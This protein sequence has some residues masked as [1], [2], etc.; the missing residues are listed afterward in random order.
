MPEMNEE[1][2]KL[3]KL[4]SEHG[5]ML[6][7]PAML[8]PANPFFDLAGEEF[9][10]RLLL[11]NGVNDVEYCLR[12]EFTIPIAAEFLQSNKSSAA[13]GYIGKIFRQRANGPA[14]FLQAGIEFLG[15]EDRNK[16][17]EKTFDF[18]L[19]AI[20]IYDNIPTL[21]LG[22]V[23]IFETLLS[24][25][26]IPKV[27]LPR[28]R[29]RFGHIKAMER[30]LARLSDPHEANTG[31][32][33]WN[34]QE[35]VKVIS[36]QM[37]AAGLSLTGSRSPEE[38]ANRYF[39]KQQLKTSKVPSETIH[40]LQNYLNVKG[41]AQGALAFIKTLALDNGINMAQSIE[42]LLNQI[43]L[44]KQKYEMSEI[45][46]DASFS[47]Q[48]DYY[49]GVVFE[50]KDKDKTIASGGEYN[51]LLERLGANRQINAAGCSI[52][53]D[54]LQHAIMKELNNE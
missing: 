22:S 52:W 11:T 20:N 44:L 15:Q 50:I 13:I 2:S 35:L 23:E 48:L 34:E 54:N 49:T 10:R 19:S 8:L 39:E 40:L 18:A 31:A 4:I 21:R 26:N 36:D 53:I 5:A 45:I 38:I 32:L 9:G 51:R 42:R 43:E 30:L 27:W 46:F 25:V 28:I 24:Q 47:P 37:I 16:T 12:P 7:N 41:E 29:H 1:A 3:S 33:P 14:E 17:L 6:S